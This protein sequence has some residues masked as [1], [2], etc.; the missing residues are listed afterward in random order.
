MLLSK[1]LDFIK[2]DERAKMLGHKLEWTQAHM[3]TNILLPKTIN[4][5]IAHP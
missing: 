1:R 5:D 4:Q 2:R 3:E